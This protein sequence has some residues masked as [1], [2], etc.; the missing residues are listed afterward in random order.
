MLREL[1]EGIALGLRY[2][3]NLYIFIEFL[4]QF[5]A[6]GSSFVSNGNW[7]SLAHSNNKWSEPDSRCSLFSSVS[8]AQAWK[9]TM[10]ATERWQRSKY[11]TCLC[12]VHNNN[13]RCLL[14][15]P[16]STAQVWKAATTAREG[17]INEVPL[18]SNACSLGQCLPS[19]SKSQGQ[20][21]HHVGLYLSLL[22]SFCTWVAIHSSFT[23]PQ[24]IKI[25]LPEGT[26]ESLTTSIVYKEILIDY[27]M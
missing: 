27:S 18:I 3:A 19:I 26:V 24:K 23:S 9:A 6:L 25:L 1:R 5:A 8:A 20:S 15:S 10:T 22:T 14:F 4:T 2:V 21:V 7:N 11:T 16:A 12:C 13:S 17:P